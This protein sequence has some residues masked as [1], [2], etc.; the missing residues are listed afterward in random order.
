MIANFGE[1]SDE[2]ELSSFLKEGIQGNSSCNN[3]AELLCF[4]GHRKCFPKTSFVFLT[5]QAMEN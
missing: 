2:Q 1:G 5:T 3:E 4:L